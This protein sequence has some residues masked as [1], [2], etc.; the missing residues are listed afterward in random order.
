MTKE[1]KIPDE[2]RGEIMKFQSR[3]FDMKKEALPLARRLAELDAEKTLWQ[4]K[5]WNFISDKFPEVSNGA[6]ELQAEKMV[7]KE[8]GDKSGYFRG[9]E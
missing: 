8:I 6:W 9:L 5:Q 1:I 2:Y 3:F 7:L 4:T